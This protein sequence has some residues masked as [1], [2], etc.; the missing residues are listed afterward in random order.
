MAELKL[1]TLEEIRAAIRSIKKGARVPYNG[2][3]QDVNLGDH[4]IYAGNGY[5]GDF[6]AGNY[7]ELEDD[8]TLEL[9]GDATVWEDQQ[10]SIGAVGKGASFPA[11]TLYK[12]SQVLAFNKAQLNQIY[13]TAQL[14]HKYEEGSEIEFHIHLAYPDNGA[15][16]SRWEFT[17]SWANINATFPVETTVRRTVGSPTTTDYHQLTSIDAS[18]EGF[19]GK[20]ISSILL[21]SLMRRGTHID[22]TYDNDIYL[23]ALDFHI[24][25]NTIGSRTEF[26]K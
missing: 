4:A 20:T 7:S 16:S 8:G 3:N 21:C 6:D 2:A 22:D 12:G 17:F 9:H 13:F 25:C 1:D 10:V 5:F 11:D 14:S 15:G 18:V 26:V 24:E 19:A 23:T